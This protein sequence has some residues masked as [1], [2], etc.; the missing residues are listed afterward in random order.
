MERTR[1]QNV[2]YYVVPTVLSSCCFFFFTIVDGIF[3]GRGVNADALGA[4]NLAFP[5]IM[6]ANAVNMLVTIG[7]V[8]ITAI[9]LGRG[10]FGVDEDT[11][12]VI[13]NAMPRFTW[14]FLLISLNT[15]ISA[16]LFSTKRTK[17][18]VSRLNRVCP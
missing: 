6:L 5:F 13:M 17:E 7:G 18:A 14:S 16:Y 1:E 4:V 2:L 10:D 8:T 11:A 15:I 12:R 9:R 3:V